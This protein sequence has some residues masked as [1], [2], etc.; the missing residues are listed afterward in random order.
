LMS[1]QADPVKLILKLFW[2]QHKVSQLGTEIAQLNNEYAAKRRAIL[3]DPSKTIADLK[4]LDEEYRSKRQALDAERA[5]IGEEL[6]KLRGEIA[7]V[8]EEQGEV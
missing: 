7:K 5:K 3:E 2:L 4:A 1:G 6:L 8:A